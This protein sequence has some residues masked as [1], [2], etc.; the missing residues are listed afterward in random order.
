[1]VS[2]DLDETFRCRLAVFRIA[3]TP[4]EA[5]AWGAGGRSLQEPGRESLCGRQGWRRAL[6]RPREPKRPMLAVMGRRLSLC[7]CLPPSPSVL[8]SRASSFLA[9]SRNGKSFPVY[10]P[11]HLAHLGL[12]GLKL[13]ERPLWGRVNRPS[14]P[15][16]GADLL[17]GR[18]RGSKSRA[19]SS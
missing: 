10:P 12:S 3:W 6:R 14:V 1:M 4:L 5:R 9:A 16:G 7:C 18:C 11:L 2:S 17:L 8:F 19:P 15:A 13:G